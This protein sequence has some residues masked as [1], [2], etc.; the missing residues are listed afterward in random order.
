M[1]EEMLAL[2]IQNRAK[3]GVGN[4][5]FLRGYIE[6]IPLPA[7]TIDVV[8][9]NCVVNLS[10]D[11][12]RVLAEIHRVLRP[13]GRLAITDVVADA[14]ADGG[15][16]DAARWSACLEGALTR[17]EYRTHLTAAGFVD[18]EIVDSHGVGDGYTSAIVRASKPHTASSDK[19]AREPPLVQAECC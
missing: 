8:I 9:S 17:D 3:A 14:P 16:M 18:V 4:V 2:A 13:G 10:P 6:D 1:T 19:G 5:E 12:P 15:A 11:K 7:N